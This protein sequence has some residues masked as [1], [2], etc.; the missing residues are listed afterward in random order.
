MHAIASDTLKVCISGQ[1][2][3]LQHI[4][5]QHNG[6]EVLWSGLSNYWSRR[7][8]VLFPVVGRLKNNQFRYNNT[9][10]TLMQHGFARDLKFTLEHLQ[11]HQ[12]MF[13]LKSSSATR[14]LYPFE[15][16]FQI[17]YTLNQSILHTEY[18]VINTGDSDMLFSVGAHPAFNCPLI[19]NTKQEEYYINF[20]KNSVTRSLLNEGLLTSNKQALILNRQKLFLNSNLFIQDALVFENQQ[21]QK[22]SIGYQNTDLITVFCEHWPYFGIWSK[23]QA[24]FLCLEPWHGITDLQESTQNLQSKRGIIRLPAA[25]TFTAGFHLDFQG[26][27]QI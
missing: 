15:F 24:P 23:P 16:T 19:P 8:P 7:A 20:Y 6:L 4:I 2:A 9:W 5:C 21:I 25:Q 14:A 26:I 17:Q 11:T 10:Y 22:L 3:E 13:Q 18:R 27:A 1:G 12:A